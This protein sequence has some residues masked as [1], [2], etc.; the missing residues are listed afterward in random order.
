MQDIAIAAINLHIPMQLSI[1]KS[2][3]D[4]L[5]RETAEGHLEG[6]ADVSHVSKL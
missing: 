3:A 6:A 2:G 1:L 4:I 5:H